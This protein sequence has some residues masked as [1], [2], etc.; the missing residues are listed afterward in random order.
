MIV[1]L[2]GNGRGLRPSPGKDRL[3]ILDHVGNWQRHGL[4]DEDREWS[5]EGKK[6]AQRG[7]RDIDELDIQQCQ[8]CFAVFR[9]GPDCCPSCG[10]ELPG[11]AR[12]EIEQVDGDLE[13]IDI[14]QIRRERKLEQ[15]QARTL[16][17]LVELGIRRGIK[18]PAGWA[19]YTA[20][21]RQGR[22][23]NGRDFKEAQE[24]MTEI[25]SGARSGSKLE[26]TF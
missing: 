4:P 26:E 17:E 9:K 11:K 1:F 10:I 25:Q 23:P 15:G 12:A 21:S 14:E 18:K 7:P 5:L 3:L 19:A 2:Q 16:R 20:A 22:K 13:M 24:M 8:D 6:K